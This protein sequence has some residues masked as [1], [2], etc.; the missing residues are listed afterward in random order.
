MK[1]GI[2]T[3]ENREIAF[4][5]YFLFGGK[6]IPRIIERLE[7]AHG[8]KVSAQTLYEWKREGGWDER[9]GRD[10]ALREDTG[11]LTFDEKMMRRIFSLIEKYERFFE[12]NAS[13]DNQAA[14][15]YTNLLRAAIELSKRMKIWE[16]K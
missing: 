14:Y 13:V 10:N 12:T 6:N 5:V 11:L 9:I 8:L 3:P 2:G 7:R 4:G 15:A 1:K 16:T